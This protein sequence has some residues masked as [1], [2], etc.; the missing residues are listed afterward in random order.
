MCLD[1]EPAKSEDCVTRNT[2]PSA[3]LVDPL[4]SS[5]PTDSANRI[6]SNPIHVPVV[7]NVAPDASLQAAFG[8]TSAETEVLTK[9]CLPERGISRRIPI[10][11]LGRFTFQ[12][13][14]S[15]H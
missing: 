1:E 2:N 14:I 6:I 5:P 15:V 10:V 3:G 13:T 12:V 7:T 9:K 11:P 8:L 4:H